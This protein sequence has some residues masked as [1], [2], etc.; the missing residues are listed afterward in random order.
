VVDIRP[1]C[2]LRPPAELAE[3]VASPPYDVI[4]TAEALEIVR[5]HPESFL[6]IIRPEVNL[7]PPDP[8]SESRYAAAAEQLALFRRRGYLVLDSDPACYVYRMQ[9][10]DGYR[11]TGLVAVCSVEDYLNGRVR[12]H[13]KTRPGPEA[14]RTRHIKV[15]G[16]QTGPVV[17]MYRDFPDLD[18]ILEEAAAG[19]PLYDLTD[20]EGVR[21]IV[22]KVSSPGRIV[23]ALEKTDRLY[24]ADGHHRAAAAARFA[25]ECR[26]RDGER[27]SVRGYEYFLA[28]LFPARG[29]RLLAY[30]RLILNTGG[31]SGRDLLRELAGGWDLRRVEG[32]TPVRAGRARLYIDGKWYEMGLASRSGETSPE[33]DVDILQRD[34]LGPVLGITD[35]RNDPRLEFLG[36]RDSV[37]EIERRVD[38]KEALAG[39]SL[40]PVSVEQI[41][42]TAD[43]NET[44]PPKSTWFEPKI[45][46]GL[47]V[48]LVD[49]VAGEH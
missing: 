14:D 32:G 35:P 29:M 12:R 30:N 47:F 41:M 20:A 45:R 17:L 42:D 15:L 3:K 11:Q 48:H 2:A 23:G 37:A 19:E 13:E 8:A 43:R 46:S 21:H 18:M 1:F 4:S 16:A 28:A 24:I 36:G 38:G 9:E 22:W 33:L 5:K 44:M 40:C 6:R 34:I 10:P 49:D 26:G 31:M 7:E 39:F 25:E 27:A